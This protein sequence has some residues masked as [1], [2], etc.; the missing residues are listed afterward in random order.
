LFQP[1]FYPQR[2]RQCLPLNPSSPNRLPQQTGLQCPSCPISREFGSEA[3]AGAEPEPL[4]ETHRRQAQLRHEVEV[5]GRPLQRERRRV[6]PQE[7]HLQQERLRVAPQ[8]A[9]VE[10][11]AA[12]CP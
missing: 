11:A 1:E 5:Q 4:V 9:V 12:E 10:R 8:A 3:V 2:S 6:A 7:L